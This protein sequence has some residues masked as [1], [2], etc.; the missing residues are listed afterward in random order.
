MF[1]YNIPHDGLIWEVD[2]YQKENWGLITVDVE[3][4]EIGYPL[5]FPKW[6]N[7]E[8]EITHDPMFF[9]INLG[10]RPYSKW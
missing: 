2:E 3:I 10:R 5:T 8:H 1:W 9:N 4:P 6:V 7:F